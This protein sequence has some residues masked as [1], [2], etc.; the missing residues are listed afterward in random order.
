M[1]A[2]VREGYGDSVRREFG[3]KAVVFMSLCNG[4]ST[5][6]AIKGGRRDMEGI[7]VLEDEVLSV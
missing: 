1:V 4:L 2:H 6:C 5:P 3:P 7:H